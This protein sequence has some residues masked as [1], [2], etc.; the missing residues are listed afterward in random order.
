[1]GRGLGWVAVVVTA[2]AC[3]G[4]GA[5]GDRCPATGRASEMNT[6]LR[7][8]RHTIRNLE[9]EVA[10]LRAQ[11]RDR[12]A[13]EIARVDPPPVVG[14]RSPGPGGGEPLPA[15]FGGSM[16]DDVEV[17]YEGDAARES[18]VRPRIELHESTRVAEGLGPVEAGPAPSTPSTVVAPLPDL[19]ERLPVTSGRIPTV[20]EQMGRA[21]ARPTGAQPSAARPVSGARPL[22]A[23]RPSGPVPG[24]PIA[25]S[26]TRPEPAAGATLDDAAKRLVA[27]ARPGE[28][29]AP[30]ETAASHAPANPAADYRRAIAALRHGEHDA[31]V[32][33][34]RSFLE[35]YPRHY[36]ADNVQFLVAESFY[37]RRLYAEALVEYKALVKDYWRGNKLPDALFKVALCELW[38]DQRDEGLQSLRRLIARFPRTKAGRIAKVRLRELTR[39]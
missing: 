15:G 26:S 28:A 23:V 32:A 3:S 18:T 17:I 21:A 36:L 33:G 19:G 27:V 9:N 12:P 20:A 11:L 35:R 39:R 25:S 22:A 14:E 13:V 10:L 24:A 37:K 2:G 31:A 8:A 1:V 29:G 5:A 7:G 16:G 6:Q 38:L 30:A 4:A 34:L